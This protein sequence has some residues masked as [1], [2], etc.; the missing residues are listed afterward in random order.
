MRFLPS[1]RSRKMPPSRN[2]NERGF[3]LL[4]IILVLALVGIISVIALFGI[5]NLT[6]SFTFIKGSGT[7]AG[8]AQLTMMRLAKEFQLIKS[9]SG[10]STSITFVGARSDADET[11][12]VTLAG[13]EL[14]LDDAVLTDQV[15][16][17]S[18]SYYDT[19]DAAAQSS[20]TN[21]E[22]KIIGI[23]LTMNGPDGINPSFQAKITTRNTP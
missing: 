13:D 17:F 10:N 11:H 18:L 23:S 14:L 2:N 21:S 5:L 4:E 9:A 7:V 22:S 3:T 6:R 12:T 16:N 1:H 20:W 19:F 15:N 8:K